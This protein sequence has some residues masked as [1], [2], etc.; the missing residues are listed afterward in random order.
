MSP[1]DLVTPSKATS[2]VYLGVAVVATIGTQLTVIRLLVDGSLSD[3][4]DQLTANPAVAFV[5][6]D[7]LGVAVAALVFMI[8]EGRRLRMSHL[9][10]YVVLTIGVGISLAFP[11]FLHVRQRRLE[12]TAD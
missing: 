5:V 6:I 11:V 1:H 2:L 9:W 12:P 3:V 10:V 4:P 8:I 7:L